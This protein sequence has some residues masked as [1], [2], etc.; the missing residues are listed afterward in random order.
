VLL[1]EGGAQG[2]AAADAAKAGTAADVGSVSGAP[3]KAAGGV[4]A[5]DVQ[6]Q[7]DVRG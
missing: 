4:V 3:G 5:A 7:R 6:Q 2:A 1:Q